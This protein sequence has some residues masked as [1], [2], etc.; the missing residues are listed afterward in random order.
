M[1]RPSGIRFP[2]DSNAPCL[3]ILS[4]AEGPERLSAPSPEPP[5][6]ELFLPLRLALLMAS[7]HCS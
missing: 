4:Q 2:R 3:M 7:L 6:D 1:P 5:V